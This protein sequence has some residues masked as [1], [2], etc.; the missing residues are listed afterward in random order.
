MS[1]GHTRWALEGCGEDHPERL[2][3]WRKDVMPSFLKTFRLSIKKIR[4]ISLW[5]ED[6]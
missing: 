1:P 4:R 3:F 5:R 2:R 6:L